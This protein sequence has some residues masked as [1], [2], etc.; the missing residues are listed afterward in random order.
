M[1]VISYW[2]F[3]API[4]GLDIITLLRYRCQG[5]T[6]YIRKATYQRPNVS[7]LKDSTTE[8]PETIRFDV[9][10]DWRHRNLVSKSTIS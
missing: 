4:H 10:S 1:K 6:E 9:Y 2:S 7:T 3:P 5:Y 8:G